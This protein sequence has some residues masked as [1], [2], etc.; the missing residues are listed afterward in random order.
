MKRYIS[1]IFQKF[2]AE[3]SW[4]NS[5]TG[6]GVSNSRVNATQYTGIRTLNRNLL[7]ELY[8][9]DGIAKKIVDLIVDDSLRGFIEAEPEM[10][11]ELNRLDFKQK[12]TECAYF[13]RLFG[14]ALLVAFSDD[15]SDMEEPI[16]FDR[17]RKVVKLV[18]YDRYDVSWEENDLNTDYYDVAYGE[19][20]VYTITTAEGDQL[21]VHRSRCAL[22][23]GTTTTEQVKR[24]NGG[25]DDSVLQPA[26]DAL[27]NYGALKSSAAELAQ[28]YNIKVLSVSGLSNWQ[29]SGQ[30]RD[31]NKR[32]RELDLQISNAQMAAIDAKNESF[33]KHLSSAS[34]MTDL[35]QKTGENLSSVTDI[36]MSKLFGM[37]ASGLN[38][39]TET[40]LKNWYDRVD[41]YRSD[42]LRPVIDWMIE[43]L[44]AQSLW[45]P[46][47]RP[48]DYDWHFPSLHTPTEKEKAEM[49]LMTAQTDNIYVSMGA[50]DAPVLYKLRY[51]SGEFQTEIRIPEEAFIVDDSLFPTEG[52][53][54]L[55]LDNQEEEENE[56]QE[57]YR[58]LLERI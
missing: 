53:E 34:G 58:R 15:G 31:F 32:L 9:D 30:I 17:L 46:A 21:R 2:K 28:D 56:K 12:L 19:P 33:Q 51:S 1:N 49:K 16:N 8:R 26:Y 55:M 6:I 20:N 35:W 4:S 10:L 39:S 52:N 37:G 40:D 22:I 5:Q 44:S 43:M 50:I 45:I 23:G 25:W 29:A 27:L 47:D 41:A 14:G 13:G 11:E 54:D 38:N 18:V 57:L 24:D 7:N 48:T 36:P 3:D 42:Q